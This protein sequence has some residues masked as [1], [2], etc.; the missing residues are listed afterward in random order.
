MIVYRHRN[1]KSACYRA[2]VRWFGAQD[3]RVIVARFRDGESFPLIRGG[4]A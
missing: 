4:G 2:L 1:R 3:L